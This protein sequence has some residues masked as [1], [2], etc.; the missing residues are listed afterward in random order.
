[1]TEEQP[2]A[3]SGDTKRI[4]GQKM[5]SLEA[6]IPFFYD[7]DVDYEALKATIKD[8]YSDNTGLRKIALH[9]TNAI[10]KIEAGRSFS[11]DVQ[12]MI[13]KPALN[14]IISVGRISA[15]RTY[16]ALCMERFTSQS[17]HETFSMLQL[18]PQIDRMDHLDRYW[19]DYQVIDRK[20]K[21]TVILFCGA[22]NRFGVEI[23]AFMLWLSHPSVNAIYLRDSRKSFYLGG[24]ASIG[25]MAQTVAK[26]RDDVAAL[27]SERVVCIGS[28]AG[29]YAALNYGAMLGADTVLCF[30]GPT[31]LEAGSQMFADKPSY[32]NVAKLMEQENLPEPDLRA[33]YGAND[34]QVHFL[35]GEGSV[36]DAM[37]TKTLDGLPNVTIEKIPDWD[38]HFIIGE[39]ARRGRLADVLAE[40][41]Y[42]SPD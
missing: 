4:Y 18:G 5:K 22:A 20:A 24:L 26:I 15:A 16:I 37:Q 2:A 14:F 40:S 6:L 19:L 21:T 25:N 12:L 23:N 10:R 3:S 29:V 36:F 42:G 39:L 32:Q 38:Q 41:V 27:G 31:S 30:S 33:I 9:A 17:V 1:M 13:A 7:D 11:L 8:L 28:S 34:V 35:Y